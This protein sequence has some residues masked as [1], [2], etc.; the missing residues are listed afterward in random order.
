MEVWKYLGILGECST[1]CLEIATRG[2]E[3]KR[4]ENDGCN[5]GVVVRKNEL[6]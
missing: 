4:V 5:E 6:V 2:L 1:G 3:K